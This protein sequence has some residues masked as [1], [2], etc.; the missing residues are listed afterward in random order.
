N[1][2]R[3]KLWKFLCIPLLFY[4]FTSGLYIPLGPGILSVEPDSTP[5]GTTV[6]L[7]IHGYNTHFK[8]D[9]PSLNV[10]LKNDNNLL[11]ASDV[12]VV[13]STDMIVEYGLPPDLRT[14]GQKDMYNLTVY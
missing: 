13:D 11:C 3:N 1:L 7:R 10:I 12:N 5:R 4:S 14:D 2:L 8:H 6:S 9:D